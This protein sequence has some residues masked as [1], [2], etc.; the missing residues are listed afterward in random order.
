MAQIS[1]NADMGEALGIHSFGNDLP[2]MQYVDLVNVAGGF[3]SG[4]PDSINA[5]VSAAHSHQLQIGAHPGL[6]DLVGFGR[7]RMAVSPEELRNIIVYQVGAVEAFCRVNGAALRHLKPHGILYTMLAEDRDLM[8]VVAETA[9]K[10]ELEVL[11]APN[12][13]HEE[14][15]EQAGVRFVP[16]LYVDLDYGDDG[17][18]T[19][20][21]TPGG[22]T[23]ASVADRVRQAVQ[24]GTVQ[25]VTG[26]TVPIHFES[27]CVHSDGSQAVDVARTV[28]E[29]LTVLGAR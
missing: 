22:R 17:R 7:R 6:P 1:I 12:T 2:L 25:T 5:T 3:H 23:L 10:F 21:R 4:D 14:V 29:T 28:A 13:L 20:Q 19:V 26:K 27:I 8:Q 15:C 18:I 11:G 16:E 24:E 9:H